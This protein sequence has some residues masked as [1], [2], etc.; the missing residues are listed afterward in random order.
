MK[1][2][3]RIC[4]V[5]NG[6]NLYPV[7]EKFIRGRYNWSIDRLKTVF[8]L[9]GYLNYFTPTI[10][11]IFRHNFN[12]D[13]ELFFREL[14]N[15]ITN[16]QILAIINLENLG[17]TFKMDDFIFS[18]IRESEF[19]AHIPR[20]TDSSYNQEIEA[21]KQYLKMKYSA[22]LPDLNLTQR[23][24]AGGSSEKKKT[25][26]I[27]GFEKEDLKFALLFNDNNVMETATM[28]EMNGEIFITC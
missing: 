6:G 11:L 23:L 8:N 28:A 12:P 15:R 5:D 3:K 1:I 26:I 20:L 24:F 21:A 18:L 2:I 7:L 13:E 9:P 4:A 14:Q 22:M 19:I 27:D 16:P 17:Y 25:E 10:L